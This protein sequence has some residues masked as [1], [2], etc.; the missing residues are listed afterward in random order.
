MSSL[1]SQRL[2]R[3][4]GVPDAFARGESRVLAGP[5]YELRRDPGIRVRLLFLRDEDGALCVGY[6]SD[7]EGDWQPVEFEP[8]SQ[9]ALG[10]YER[11][12]KRIGDWVENPAGRRK[13]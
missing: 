2:L 3:Q 7:A 6:A 11:R 5:V 1:K 9:R 13:R 12:L 10:Y 8:F 4:F